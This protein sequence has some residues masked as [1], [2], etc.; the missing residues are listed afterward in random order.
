[1]RAEISSVFVPAPTHFNNFVIDAERT[2]H[3]PHCC[4]EKFRENSSL[5]QHP[6]A[7]PASLSR[8]TWQSHIRY[9][10]EKCVVIKRAPDGE[11]EQG[12]FR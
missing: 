1:M 6:A 7:A 11:V 10:A 8:P 9:N 12:L 2:V 4:E 5:Y 3:R